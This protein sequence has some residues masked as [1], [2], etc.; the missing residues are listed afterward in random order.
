ML[1]LGPVEGYT[2]LFWDA[3]LPPSLPLLENPMLRRAPALLLALSLAA[4][5]GS[6]PVPDTGDPNAVDD[7]G[8]GFGVAEDC[9]D[10]NPDVNPA[11]VE[12]CDGVDNDCDSRID[13]EDDDL[14]G[15]SGLR[16]FLDLDGDGFGDD[17]TATQACALPTEDA[18]TVGGDCDDQDRDVHPDA[19]EICD[20]ADR[21]EDCNGDSDDDD[22]DVDLSTGSLWYPDRDS[23]GFGD[24]GDE[25][26]LACDAF[27]RVGTSYVADRTDCDDGRA[28]INP[29]ATEICDPDDTD[30]DC[31]GFADDDDAFVDLSTASTW[32]PDIDSDGFGDESADGVVAC[33]APDPTDVVD[34][35]DCDDTSVDTNPDA[36]EL[37]ADGVDNDCDGNLDEVCWVAGDAP[38]TIATGL[39]ND[40]FGYALSNAADVDGDG[41]DDM[42]VG[43]ILDSTVASEA[44]SV[45]LFAGGSTTGTLSADSDATW[46]LR[47]EN[48]SDEVGFAVELVDDLNG[49]GFGELLVG[50]PGYP[51]GAES[52]AGALFLGPLAGSA[53]LGDADLLVEGAEGSFLG[54]FVANEVGDVDGDGV[55]DLAFGAPSASSPG[56]VYLFSS[57]DRGLLG[58]EDAAATITGSSGALLG[59]NASRPTDINGDGVGDVVLGSGGALR[60]WVFLGPL[61]GAL[62]VDDADLVL[63]GA[64]DFGD[65]VATG[66]LDGDGLD[67]VAVGAPSA[68]GW[69]GAV[70]T[71]LSPITSGSDTSAAH[72]T[73]NGGSLDS[74][75]RKWGEVL[76]ADLDVDGQQDL[77][78]GARYANDGAGQIGVFLGPQAGTAGLDD[79]QYRFDGNDPRDYLGT[80]LSLGDVDGDGLPDLFTGSMAPDSVG[81]AYLFPGS[82]L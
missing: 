49:D 58:P 71:F 6:N 68:G 66:D 38:L 44:G 2:A 10:A 56:A 77:L 42:A 32:Y 1:A 64:G 80:E 12:V 39:T 70:Y 35:S 40:R 69:A 73:V 9:D 19:T 13:D 5:V 34:A 26:E 27:V 61:I 29:D 14:D 47:G 72:F 55:A 3:P 4:C 78:L 74:L 62:A 51:G 28:D 20:R 31:D 15:S 30:E 18:T 53:T 48:A 76:I 60:T 25:G 79:A 24:D 8:D 54:W 82:R 17:S 43:A 45:Y 50:A 41:L 75:G 11:A 23:D 33:D 57:A 59:S 37:C 46:T 65:D 63:S 7:D 36:L 16:Y 21:D 52:G 22:R 81:Q 67:D